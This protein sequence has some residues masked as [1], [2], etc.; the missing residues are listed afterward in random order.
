M[1]NGDGWQIQAA[2]SEKKKKKD[3]H[4]LANTY[5]LSTMGGWKIEF[6]ANLDYTVWLTVSQNHLPSKQDFYFGLSYRCNGTGAKTQNFTIA[7]IYYLVWFL[8][9]V[10]V[11]YSLS[12]FYIFFLVVL[13][14]EPKASALGRQVLYHLLYITLSIL[15]LKFL[16]MPLLRVRYLA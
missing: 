13:G 10:S 5:N 2:N 6:E 12:T 3:T 1:A 9:I 11:L 14:L 8:F 15:W 4:T 16:G 7:I